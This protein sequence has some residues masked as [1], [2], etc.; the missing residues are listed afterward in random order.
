MPCSC[1]V[2]GRRFPPQSRRCTCRPDKPDKTRHD[3]VS[4][5]LPH[6]Y[7]AAPHATLPL[8]L[9]LSGARCSVAATSPG[10]LCQRSS[11]Q[12]TSNSL[13]H[14]LQ[15]PASVDR[16]L[17]QRHLRPHFPR[18]RNSSPLP[19][20]G[21]AAHVRILRGLHS[22]NLSI[23]TFTRHTLICQMSDLWAPNRPLAS[24]RRR[25]LSLAS[26]S[27]TG[28]TSTLIY[29]RGHG[30]RR[31]P[32]PSALRGLGQVGQGCCGTVITNT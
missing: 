19:H 6:R 14:A 1:P 16:L 8:H 15:V 13:L 31:D 22:T 5:F 7:T 25:R 26:A 32:S 10:R 28:I 12:P 29:R 3:P 20:S 9:S 30:A 18:A 17:S 2:T 21:I 11:L 23:F 27:K 24:A 4:I